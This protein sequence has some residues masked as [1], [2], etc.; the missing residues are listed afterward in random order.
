M[1]SIVLVGGGHSHAIVLQ[2][3]QHQPLANVSLTVITPQA[4]TPYSG[5]L[6]GY[7]AGFYHYPECHIDIKQLAHSVGATLYIDTVINLDL[8]NKRIICEHQAPINFD[9][10]SIDIGSTP[11]TI[12]IPGA[13]EYAIPAKPVDNLL[14]HWHQLLTECH[15]NPDLAWKIAIVGG[16]AG[17]IELAFA[18]QGHLSQFT[19]NLEVSLL[20]RGDELLP[21][22]P[23]STRN[24]IQRILEEKNIKVFLRESVRAISQNP[25]TSLNI[26]CE[27]SFQVTC[28][29]VFW[30]TQAS[31]SPWLKQ[32]GLTTDSQGFILVDDTLRSL[33]HSHVFA[34]GDIATMVNHP[35]PKAGVFAVRQGKPLFRNLQR[36]ISGK[37]PIPFIPQKDY[38][39][40]IGTGDGRAIAT[41]GKF[42][43][44]PHKFIWQWKD[45]IDRQFMKKF[46]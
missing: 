38:L 10:A 41:R 34:A 7:I 33:S 23:S 31:A 15:R 27:S 26:I 2:K 16:G 22:Y 6:P 29:R 24:I 5:M 30:V 32:T 25:D 43:L 9:I 4:Q 1:K 20:H 11:A 45:I 14:N 44:P 36:V 28:N 35:R 17:G 13:G 8:E 42:T 18:I 21:N 37:P 19:D 40:L 12:N 3:W 39:S 46:N